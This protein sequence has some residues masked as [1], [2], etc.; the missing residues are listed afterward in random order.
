MEFVFAYITTKD[1]QQA[2]SIGQVLV[3]ERLA[4]CVNILEPM[5]SLYWWDGKITQ[6]HE[7]VLIAKTVGEKFS[8]LTERVKQ[9]HSYSCPCVV[10]LPINDGSR[11]YLDWLRQETGGGEPFPP[12]LP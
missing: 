3:Q 2:L 4:A 12:S 9:L 7:A 10:A 5:T 6:D 8:A 11:E 1:K